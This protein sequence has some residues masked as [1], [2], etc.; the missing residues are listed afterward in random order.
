MRELLIIGRNDRRT[1]QLHDRTVNMALSGASAEV[2]YI[3]TAVSTSSPRICLAQ[4][5]SHPSVVGLLS[6]RRVGEPLLV[7]RKQRQLA[8]RRPLQRRPSAAA[9]PA[10]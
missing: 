5:S 6:D 4:I 9:I 3:K 7:R 2:N 8:N 1:D 10:S